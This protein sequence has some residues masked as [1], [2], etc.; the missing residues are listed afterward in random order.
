M[1]CLVHCLRHHVLQDLKVAHAKDVILDFAQV[2]V[3]NYLVI[4][5]LLSVDLGCSRPMD[6][7]DL[8]PSYVLEDLLLD[9]VFFMRVQTITATNFFI[10]FYF[11]V[12]PL[13]NGI[14]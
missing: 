5:D 14:Q 4:R 9:F 6:L 2:S 3:D 13:E 12:V 7:A 10:F 1:I 11:F 8:K